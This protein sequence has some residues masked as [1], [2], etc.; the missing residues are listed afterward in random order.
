[1]ESS[2]SYKMQPFNNICKTN[3]LKKYLKEQVIERNERKEIGRI[4]EYLIECINED[5]FI[6]D[7]I[8]DIAVDI[9]QSYDMVNYSLKIIQNLQP[10][11]I[12]AKDIKESF[13]IQ[14]SKRN[15]YDYKIYEI[16]YNFME[17]FIDNKYKELANILN[18]DIKTIQQYAIIIKSL[19]P[20]PSRSLTSVG[21]S[22]YQDIAFAQVIK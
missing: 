8:R 19:E 22:E 14:L 21:A 16:I 17:L 13:K 15:I 1:M 6:T 10:W 9:T 5:G 11:G 7:D 4:C 12:G 18:E 3:S 2:I 20:I